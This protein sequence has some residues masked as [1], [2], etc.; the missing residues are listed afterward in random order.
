MN[1]RKLWL[2]FWLAIVCLSAS[3][4]PP[5]SVEQQ[6]RAR[7]G[8]DADLAQLPILDGFI[9]IKTLVAE[10]FDN[11]HTGNDVC[12]YA[13]GS[14]VAGTTLAETAALDA[15]SQRLQTLGW[16]PSLPKEDTSRY[17]TRDLNE[18]IVIYSYAPSLDI[19]DAVGYAQ[20]K[21]QYKSIIIIEVD[22]IL[23]NQGRC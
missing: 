8:L 6:Q 14:V 3:C 11:E 2:L 13:V 12:Y 10:S 7:K 21:Q 20:L 17:L 9:V 22:Y 5:V 23:P 15:Y 4:Y 19:Q 18:R 16:V 1:K